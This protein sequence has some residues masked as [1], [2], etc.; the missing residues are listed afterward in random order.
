MC[1]RKIYYGHVLRMKQNRITKKVFNIKMEN[2]R[3]K[4]RSRCEEQDKGDITQDGRTLE[5]T[6]EQPW[7]EKYK[8][9]EA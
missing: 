6:K 4:P 8:G 7:R 1:N 5:E 3:Q 9:G 2:T